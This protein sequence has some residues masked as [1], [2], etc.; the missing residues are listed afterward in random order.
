[1]T[2][3]T[4]RPIKLLRSWQMDLNSRISDTNT[5]TYEEVSQIA[6][7]P[8][9]SGSIIISGILRV[10]Q[11]WVTMCRHQTMDVLRVLS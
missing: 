11:T 7:L 1:M 8:K 3:S 5:E 9:I 2:F 10:W 6:L 4:F